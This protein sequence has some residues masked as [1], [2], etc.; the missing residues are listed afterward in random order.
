M[1]QR[2]LILFYSSLTQ[3]TGCATKRYPGSVGVQGYVTISV[4]Q[5]K[6]NAQPL[7]LN[8][9]CVTDLVLIISLARVQLSK[10][11]SSFQLTG[12]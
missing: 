6:T 3:H 1:Q 10:G 7:L 2:S 5:R 8:I 11:N 4:N 12:E 9:D